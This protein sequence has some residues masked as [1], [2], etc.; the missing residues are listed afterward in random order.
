MIFTS[1]RVEN[2]R[3]INN[4]HISPC[5]KLNLF[6][7]PNGSG[8]TAILEGIHIL[9]RARSFRSP[10]I[11][12]VIQ[13]QQQVMTVSAELL[14]SQ[15]LKLVTGIEKSYGKTLIKYQG[16]ALK[17]VSEQARNIPLVFITPDSHSLVTGSPKD[18]RHWL[19]WALFH[20]EPAYMG[21]WKNYQTALRNRNNLLKRAAV[22]DQ[23][24]PWE[25]N[26]V[27][28]AERLG[29]FREGFIRRLQDCFNQVSKGVFE[30]ESTLCF[31]YGDPPDR[32]LL[33]YL[34]ECR[35]Q[36]RRLGFTRFGPH[37]A[38]LVFTN[39]GEK[40]SQ[41]FS[42]GQIKRFVL[43]LQLALAEALGDLNGEKPVLLVDDYSAELDE[44]AQVEVL[45]Q[46]QS[47]AGQVFLTSTEV[48]TSMAD[49][50]DF[51]V[52]HVERGKIN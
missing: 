8:K 15:Q 20:V 5:S 50:G 12:E 42:R 39:A 30:T 51:R 46:L 6:V 48:D 34:D 40:V 26:L 28:N 37:K 7:G 43:C 17:T 38:D 19:D 45:S 1:I 32:S 33:D 4:I 29:V 25:K 21:V 24:L 18:R 2:V 11:R 27:S 49:L 41:V 13:R 14:S 52:F 47:Y 44:Q 10:R 36:D 22:N 31:E 23:V 3:N 35:E 9:S 16:R